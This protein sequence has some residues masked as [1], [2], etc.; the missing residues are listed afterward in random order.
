MNSRALTLAAAAC[1]VLCADASYG[2]TK[3]VRIDCD[4]GKTIASALNQEADELIIEISGFCK[5]DPVIER[6]FV[7]IRGANQ[8]P[9]LDGIH[10]ATPGQVLAGTGGQEIGET[11]VTIRGAQ[12]VRLEYLSLGE[13]LANRTGV[14]AISGAIATV[15][16]CVVE[17]SSDG[18]VAAANGTLFVEDS[19]VRGNGGAGALAVVGGQLTL[20]DTIVLAN[21]LGLISLT[22]GTITVSGGSIDGSI[23]ALS[24]GNIELG[25]FGLDPVAHSAPFNLISGDSSLRVS[26]SSTL[27]GFFAVADFSNLALRDGSTITGTLNCDGGGDAFC[28]TPLTQIIGFSNC[29][30]CPNP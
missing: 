21:G 15:S 18:G 6:D 16:N 3:T 27:A 14:A 23:F 26:S 4:R 8:D 24:D 25:G 30:Q 10:G 28:D 12:G 22:G 13:G 2:E 9:A 1:L 19:I 29:G 11:V 20:I 5:E 17:N 7:T